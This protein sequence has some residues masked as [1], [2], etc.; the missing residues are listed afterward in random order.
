MA[1]MQ[2]P[3]GATGWYLC[4]WEDEPDSSYVELT[5]REAY[6]IQW[7]KQFQGDVYAIRAMRGLLGASHPWS[8]DE[9]VFADSLGRL[10]TGAWK[11]RRDAFSLFPVS[12]TAEPG[13]AAP[14]PIEERRAAS[15]SPGPAPDAPVFPSDI[16]PA[17]IA[18]AQQEAAALGV[19]FCEECLRAQLAGQ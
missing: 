2:V 9:Q 6:L 7:L 11:A 14:F 16:D 13:E 17:A 12:G 15:S 10:T 19:P 1:G 8:D 4:D 5:G 18:Q 3:I